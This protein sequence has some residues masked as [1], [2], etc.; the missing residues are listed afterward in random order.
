MLWDLLAP[1]TPLL[2]VLQASGSRLKHIDHFDG[3][4][5]NGTWTCYG[6][7]DCINRFLAPV[8]RHSPHT[9]HGPHTTPHTL[10]TQP[11]TTLTTSDHTHIP[12]YTTPHNPHTTPHTALTAH[13]Q[14]LIT[15]HN[16]TPQLTTTHEHVPLGVE[17]ISYGLHYKLRLILMENLNRGVILSN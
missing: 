3:G 11:S 13:S 7:Y 12:P 5:H 1:P 2:L 9:S 10:I 17:T 15:P 4:T 14:P 16:F 6:Y 8:S